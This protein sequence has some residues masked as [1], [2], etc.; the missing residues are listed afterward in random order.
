M[1]RAGY[2]KSLRASTNGVVFHEEFTMQVH[3]LLMIGYNA[4]N[5]AAFRNE[6]ENFITARLKEGIHN[7]IQNRNSPEEF[8]HFV[9][10]YD[11]PIDAG[12][13]IGITRPRVDI[14][15][16]STQRR[17]HPR[18]EFEAKRLNSKN[19]VG[20]YLGKDG[21]GC[22]LSGGYSRDSSS[23]GMLGYVQ[24]GTLEHWAEKLKQ[25]FTGDPELYF[26]LPNDGGWRKLDANQVHALPDIYRTRHNRNHVGLPIT[27]YHTLL[28]F[29]NQ[30]HR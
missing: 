4:L 7:Y 13:K 17:P 19:G 27:I 25:K 10:H 24:S 18:F 5:A 20:D 8:Q 1:K 28:D 14:E 15:F 3:A 30:T 2:N 12:D 26:I 9:V 16:V 11:Q 22:F 29:H 21:L 6:P 23:A